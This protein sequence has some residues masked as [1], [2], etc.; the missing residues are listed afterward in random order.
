VSDDREVSVPALEYPRL[1][2]YRVIGV[3]AERLRE[4]IAQVLGEQ[5][6]T[7]E[8]GNTSKHGRYVSISA[9]VTVRSCSPC[10]SAGG[11]CSR[12]GGR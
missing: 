12:G 2:E 6:H 3:R 10:L 8:P 7:V 4:I 11:R 5:E 1:W 9:M